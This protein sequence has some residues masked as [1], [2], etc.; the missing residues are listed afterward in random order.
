MGKADAVG[1][2]EEREENV[3]FSFVSE[4]FATGL[5][6]VDQQMLIWSLVCVHSSL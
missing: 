6:M 2:V 4:R 1:L 5:S 3:S